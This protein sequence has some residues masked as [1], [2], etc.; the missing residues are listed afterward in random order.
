MSNPAVYLLHQNKVHGN[1]LR[2]EDNLGEAIHVH[3]GDSRFSITVEEF[4]KMSEAM[5]AAAKELFELEGHDWEMID[6]S[7]LDWNWLCDYESLEK[8]SRKTVKLGDLYTSRR[9][10][11]GDGF[12][13][14]VKL[15]DS[16]FVEELL[17]NKSDIDQYKEVNMFG[18]SSRDRLSSMYEKIMNDDYPFDDKFICVSSQNIIYDGDH[19]AACLYVKHG[20][21]YEIPVME[22]RFKN[23]KSIN[24]VLKAE[25]KKYCKFL[26]KTVLKGTKRAVKRIIKKMLFIS[27]DNVKELEGNEAIDMNK[28]FEWLDKSQ[29]KYYM[30]GDKTLII[31]DMDSFAKLF[32]NSCKNA[33][34]GYKLLYSI[35][36]PLVLNTTDGEVMVW[37]SLCCK[38]R[39]ENSLLPL[40]KFCNEYA[41]NTCFVDAKG[42]YRAS[43][44]V[45]VLYIIVSALLEKQL[46]SEQEQKY[47]M[48]NADVLDDRD[49]NAMMEK[50]FF[51]YTDELISMIKQG[52]FEECIRRYIRNI[53]Y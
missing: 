9:I 31:Q 49:F 52:R 18:Q 16:L 10:Y 53:N 28:V 51:G 4:E 12:Q 25:N 15:K 22:F 20:P 6:K 19:R 29:S 11:R 45:E 44:E 1:V 24:E 42:I 37:E 23:H 33:Y 14:T 50:E 39:F 7:S 27:S 2:I 13:R 5:E 46:F 34:K 40:D 8:I 43:R 41:W 3:Y 35:K 17:K 32:A 47:I 30:V 21:D 48:D 38:S 36:S 26:I